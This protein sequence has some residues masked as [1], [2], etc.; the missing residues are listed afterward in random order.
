MFS[1]FT[2]GVLVWYLLSLNLVAQFQSTG[3]AAQ[4]QSRKSAALTSLQRRG[5]KM[6]QA[7]EAEAKTLPA[8]MRAYLLLEIASSYSAIN[9][10][11]ERNLR[12]Q[13]FQ[14]TLSIE[15]DDDNKEFVQD[16]IL[17]EL[18]YN[19]KA[20]LEKALPKA[21]PGLRNRYTAELSREYARSKGYDHIRPR[22]P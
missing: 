1:A 14:S 15:D 6:L 19:S 16:Q 2:R 21:L 10:A 7:A 12:F 22:R 17:R 5:L 18:L 13:A 9:P 11:K 8:P 20:D 3:A 4:T